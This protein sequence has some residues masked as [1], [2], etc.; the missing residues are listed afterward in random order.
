M[1]SWMLVWKKKECR[2]VVQKLNIPA[3]GTSTGPH[4]PPRFPRPGAPAH[5]GDAPTIP[6]YSQKRQGGQTL[7]HEPEIALHLEE[8]PFV[9]RK[10]PIVPW[11]EIA[12]Y[13][14]PRP[15]AAAAGGLEDYYTSRRLMQHL[16][17]AQRLVPPC[18]PPF[19]KLPRENLHHSK[20][21]SAFAVAVAWRGPRQ[22]TCRREKTESSQKLV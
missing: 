5:W 18:R 2:Y 22:V 20:C 8:P 13:P 15:P 11:T 7:Q 3:S 1:V 10:L 21:A 16:L 12:V 6:L 17:K 19:L 4:V 9:G 14:G